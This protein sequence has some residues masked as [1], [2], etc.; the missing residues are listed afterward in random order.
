ML[1]H[2][3]EKISAGVVDTSCERPTGYRVL[4]GFLLIVLKPYD[5]LMLLEG[6]G[7]VKQ[8]CVLISHAAVP[9]FTLVSVLQSS[10]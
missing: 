1:D 6:K 7:F 4:L 9:S 8:R 2:R 3:L 5:S 10:S